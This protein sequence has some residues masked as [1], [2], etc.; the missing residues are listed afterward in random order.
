[1]DKFDI[2]PP[3]GN[4][5]YIIK[6]YS[7]TTWFGFINSGWYWYKGNTRE[8]KVNG[9]NINTLN[10]S[11]TIRYANDGS[12]GFYIYNGN[13]FLGN[14]LNINSINNNY[15]IKY[16]NNTTGYYWFDANRKKSKVNNIGTAPNNGSLIKYDNSNFNE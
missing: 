2:A 3:N 11:Y 15:I 5:T 13:Y 10:Q 9:I 14:K 16:H 4:N 1:M 6:Y 7:D 8:E 12:K